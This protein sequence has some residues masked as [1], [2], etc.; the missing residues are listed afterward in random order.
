MSNGAFGFKPAWLTVHDAASN[1]AVSCHPSAEMDAL[2][3]PV[4]LMTIVPVWL[5]LQPPVPLLHFSDA[6]HVIAESAS[7]HFEGPAGA[8]GGASAGSGEIA[9]GAAWSETA[10][11]TPQALIIGSARTVAIAVLLRDAIL[12]L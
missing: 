4:R 7:G 2:D 10:P 1:P 8:D 6:L 5:M 3:F 12:Q 11:R 9:Y